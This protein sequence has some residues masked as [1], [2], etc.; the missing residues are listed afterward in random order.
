MEIS[1]HNTRIP[2]PRPQWT[3]SFARF[4]MAAKGVVY[5]L[6]GALAFMA[7]FEING[8]SEQG[9]GK[10]GV[11]QFILEQPFGKILLG[12]VALGL[13][14]YTIWRFI[15]A[16]M[17]SERKGGDAKGIGKRLGYAFSGL[18]YG[19]LAFYAAKLVLGS[20]GGSGGGDSRQTLAGKLLEQPFGQWL[21]GIVAVG[22]MAMGLYQIYKAITGKYLKNIQT[23]Q[24]KSD[25]KDMLMKAGKVGY[26]ARGIVWG[27]I[28]FLFLKAAMNSNAQEAGGTTSAFQFLEQSYGSILL[29]A[30][31]LG[32][33][34]YGVFMFVRARYE[35]INT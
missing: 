33:V 12:I 7:A 17:D 16:F 1:I 5:T 30:I 26:I 13:V 31:A 2:H 9:A 34:C 19:S 20:G 14:C 3:E 15:Q 28:G 10:Q 11:F 21:V 25:I 24:I 18:I 32:L 22:T 6:V 4:G 23:A 27:I 8:N 35:A 29:G